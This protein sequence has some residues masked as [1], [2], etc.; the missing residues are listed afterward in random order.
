MRGLVRTDAGSEG[1]RHGEG[2]EEVRLGQLFV[3]VVLE[4]LMSCM[5]LTLGAVAVAARMLDAMLLPTVLALREAMAVR[6][7]LA[8]LDGADDLAVRSGEMGIAL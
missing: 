2:K 7:A 4:P 5:L 3:Q 1:L 8:L 6:T